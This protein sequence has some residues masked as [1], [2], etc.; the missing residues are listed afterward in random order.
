[1]LMR[2]LEESI[3]RELPELMENKVRLRVIGRTAGVPLPVRP[4]LEH[5]ARETRDNSGLTLLVAFNYGGRRLAHAALDAPA[6]LVDDLQPAHG[7]GFVGDVRRRPHPA[8]A[9]RL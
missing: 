7:P 6:L 3:Y 2:L 4:G 1:M 8:R 5:V 9:P